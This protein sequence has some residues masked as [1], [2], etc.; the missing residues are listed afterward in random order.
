MLIIFIVNSFVSPLMWTFNID[1]CLKRLQILKIENKKNPNMRHNMSQ[2]KLNELYEYVDI[3]LAYKYSYISKT[4]LMTFFYLPL[5]PFGIIFSIC[6]LSL[7]FFLEKFNIG[8]IYKRPEMM[9]E[10]IIKFY[11]SYFEV[12]FLMLALGDFIFLKDEYNI[13]YWQFIN[14]IIFIASI[15]IPYGSYL[16]YNFIGVNQ[17]QI[18]NKTYDEAY[19]TFFNDYELMNPFTRKIGTINYLKRLKEK[20]YI[21]E[22]EFQNQKKY[23]ESLNFW[24][25]ITLEKPSRSSKV[26]KL[27]GKKQ[28]LLCNIG[29]NENYKKVKR[30]FELIK[31][32]YKES[33]EEEKNNNNNNNSNIKTKRTIRCEDRVIELPNILHLV[34]TIFGT[35]NEKWEERQLVS[36]SNSSESEISE[37]VKSKNNSKTENSS[38]FV[39]DINDNNKSNNN[40]NNESIHNKT[41]NNEGNKNDKI[42]KNYNSKIILSEIK[43]EINK[44]KKNLISPPNTSTYNKNDLTYLKN[45]NSNNNNEITNDINVNNDDSNNASSTNL[46]SNEQKKSLMTNILNIINQFFNKFKNHPKDDTISSERYK[47]DNSNSNNIIQN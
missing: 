14:I 1:F 35:E 27:L 3:D 31:K 32:I 24:Q 10:A 19:F 29:F 16:N 46:N 23:I 28:A 20:D 42:K 44:R 43:T 33:P 12:N 38:P 22:E 37:V 18:I 4:L 39:F 6:G 26:K 36:E 47:F 17:S 41:Y 11:V 15:I 5:F 2:R 13:N 34:G 25:I 7:G 8:H 21:S 9:S 45:N 30:L 40:S